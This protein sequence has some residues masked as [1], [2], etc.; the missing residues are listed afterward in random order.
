METFK[1][2]LLLPPQLWDPPVCYVT[3]LVLWFLGLLLERQLYIWDQMMA[4]KGLKQPPP[5]PKLTGPNDVGG[6]FGGAGDC[7]DQGTHSLLNGVS[8]SSLLY[9]YFLPLLL[10]IAPPPFILQKCGPKAGYGALCI[11]K[12]L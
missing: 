5:N 4:P 3:F 2:Q 6:R 9:P 10:P 8:S 11:D 7:G 1:Y 12:I